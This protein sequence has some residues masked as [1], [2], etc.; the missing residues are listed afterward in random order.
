MAQRRDSNLVKVRR[1]GE[2]ISVDPNTV[3]ITRGSVPSIDDP[4]DDASPDDIFDDVANILPAG[5]DLLGYW[6]LEEGQGSITEGLGTLGVGGT[7]INTTWENSLEVENSSNSVGFNGVD[8]RIDLN[9]SVDITSLAFSISLWA[10]IDSFG[11]QDGRFISKATGVNDQDHYW[12]ISTILN[13]GT[14]RLRF[15]LKAGGTTTTLIADSG[16][17]IIGEWNHIAAI[18]D[19]NSMSLYLNG[20]SI[21]SIPKSGVIS[22]STSVPVSIGN[23]PP[24]AGLRPFHGKIDEVRLYERAITLAEIG[25][26]AQLTPPPPPPP[27]RPN[28]KT[29]GPI[30][31]LTPA[32]TLYPNAVS[33]TGNHLGEFIIDDY[34]VIEYG[35][36]FSDF[37]HS[38]VRIHTRYPVN[39]NNFR[40]TG[41]ISNPYEGPD[42]GLIINDI[43]Q[44]GPQIPATPTIEKGEI[45]GFKVAG[46]KGNNFNIHDCNIFNMYGDGIILDVFSNNSPPVANSTTILRN[47]IHHLGF[48]PVIPFAGGIGGQNAI[49]IH[50][51]N[52]VLIK[53]NFIETP[54]PNSLE[55]QQE[56]AGPGFMPWSNGTAIYIPPTAYLPEPRV[57]DIVI[58]YNWINALTWFDITGWA[59]YNQP[60]VTIKDNKLFRGYEGQPWN[61]GIQGIPTLDN[62]TWN[63]DSTTSFGVIDFVTPIPSPGWYPEGAPLP[64]ITPTNLVATP[65]DNQ[66]YLTWDSNTQIGFAGFNVY[67]SIIQGSNY[68]L[69]NSV[70]VNNY[71]DNS[72]VNNTTYYYVVTSLTE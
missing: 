52:D 50:E 51:G 34:A 63:T 57:I 54:H 58:D 56:S 1:G 38:V 67:R 16:D 17:L 72:A 42:Y 45:Q 49:I 6:P 66:V 70:S 30:G 33:Y 47:W 13:G 20:V 15:R 48:N 36:T 4:L 64:P 14:H 44:V 40:L 3:N 19:G 61:W 53:H 7:L 12:M 55:Y 25:S 31:T 11:I 22:S 65:G 28:L 43:T 21:A 26:L 27:P 37:Y 2:I 62:N 9:G 71:T 60:I 46:V 5:T 69:L 10:N 68:T 59:S 39:L 29:T 24:G 32:A 35:T 23:Q 41:N 18:Y 8:S